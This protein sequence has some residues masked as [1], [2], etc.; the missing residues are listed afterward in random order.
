MTSNKNAGEHRSREQLLAELDE[1]RSEMAANQEKCRQEILSAQQKGEQKFR[2]VFDHTSD[3][4]YVCDMQG[5]ILDVNEIAC[6]NLGYDRDELLQMTIMDIDTPEYACAAPQRVHQALQTGHFLFESVHRRKDGS[7]FPVEINAHKIQYEGKMC[8]LGVVR[9]ISE[10]KQIEQEL[11][12]AMEQI[13]AHMENSPLAIIEF[14]PSYRVIRW[15]SAAERLFGWKT[16]EIVGKTISDV[17]WVHD[18]D[19]AI[20]S[21]LSDDMVSGDRSRNLCV[22]RNYRKDGSTVYCEWYNSAIYDKDGRMTSVLSRVLDVTE[23]IKAEESLLESEKQYRLLFTSNPNPMFVF[24]EETLRFLAVNTAAVQ[25]YGWSQEEFLA[26]TVLD[27][28]PVEDRRQVRETLHRHQGARES[29]IGVYRHIR[30]NGTIM[31]MEITVSSIEFGGR[32]GRLCL[33]TDITERKKAELALAASELKFRSL[34]ESSPDAIFIIRPEGRIESANPAACAMLKWTE[35]EFTELGLPGVLDPTDPR[36]EAALQDHQR[37]GRIKGRELAAI[38]KHGEKF[39]VEI[40][41]VIVSGDPNR[42]FVIMRDISE[43]KKAAEA[44]QRLNESLEQRVAERTELA[45]ARAR[46]LQ[47]LSVELIE[48]EERERRRF[49]QLLHD[50]LQ[51][52]LAAAKLQLQSV[53]G[54]LSQEPTIAFVMDLLEESIGKSRQLSHE[55]SPAVLQFPNFVN[56]LKWLA[57]QTKEKFGLDVRLDS[58]GD[59]QIEDWPLRRFLFRAVQELLFNIVKHADVKSARIDIHRSDARVKITVGDYGN[60]FDIGLLNHSNTQQGFG[61]LSIRERANH[62]GGNLAI[63]TSPGKGSIF[64]LSMP[65][66]LAVPPALK[67]PNSYA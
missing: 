64:T 31:D 21:Q 24:D 32:P 48:V 42:S 9:D 67:N 19:K 52:L 46:Q 5:R 36:L 17:K 11:R 44:W 59:L 55:L 22:N 43:R 34:F 7:V 54:D 65:L 15:S 53:R 41:S 50:D 62:M 56:A 18:D 13:E 47:A 10:R 6:N 30:K 40:D 8:T 3:P 26:M 57:H 35:S 33:M 25:H 45:E 60:G 2:S 61:L 12:S 29:D 20:V 49:S 4:I 38:R 37:T 58:D 51:Q 1:L 39:P 27:V 66:A 63:E 14:D 28:R 16:D 23:R